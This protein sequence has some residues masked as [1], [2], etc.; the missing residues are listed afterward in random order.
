MVESNCYGGPG[1]ESVRSMLA[2]SPRTVKAMLILT[3]EDPNHVKAGD[4]RPIAHVPETSHLIGQLWG[5][6]QHFGG[7]SSFHMET[8][9]IFHRPH[10]SW[11]QPWWRIFLPLPSSASGFGG[12]QPNEG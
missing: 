5:S 12:A 2:Q 6:S 10:S 11:R 8:A 1:F 3:P 4:L 9:A 7:R